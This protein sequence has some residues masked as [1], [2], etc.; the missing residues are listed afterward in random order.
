MTKVHID[1]FKRKAARIALACGQSRR[2]VAADLGVGFSTLAKWIQRSRPDDLPP[3][4]DIDLAKEHERLRKENRLLTG[5]RE[6]LKKQ[7]RSSRPIG[8]CDAITCRVRVKTNEICLCRRPCKAS[9]GRT[10]VPHAE[11][12]IAWLPGLAGPSGQQRQRYDMV[13][14]AHRSRPSSRPSR[15]NCVDHRLGH[16]AAR[17]AIPFYNTSILALWAMFTSLRR[18]FY[19]TRRKHSAIGGT[20]PLKFERLSA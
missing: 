2:Q 20:S 18:G 13:L 6:L 10:P 15:A 9:S 19:R 7:R 17:S 11:C 12:Y 3:K 5:E 4:F 8:D 14:L 16:R 1:Q